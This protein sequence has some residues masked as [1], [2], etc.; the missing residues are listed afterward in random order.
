MSLALT[1]CFQCVQMQIGCARQ[2]TSMQ[3]VSLQEGHA[4]NLAPC[5]KVHITVQLCWCQP[6]QGLL[7]GDGHFCFVSQGAASTACMW[8]CL[9]DVTILAGPL[10]WSKISQC[11]RKKARWQDKTMNWFK[12][13]KN[14][15]TFDDGWWGKNFWTWLHFAKWSPIKFV[16]M[17]EQEIK[18]T[19]ILAGKKV[20]CDD[21]TCVIEMVAL[22]WCIQQAI[23]R[24][25]LRW[26][27]NG[28]EMDYDG[29][30]QNCG[31]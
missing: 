18:S 31:A 8:T 19:S 6:P 12:V 13:A 14:S 29:A 25:F 27:V 24:V 3:N 1:V 4:P 17:V 5:S 26:K 22:I 16:L 11:Q 21:V 7:P 2:C 28:L 9:T 15:L 20:F 23:A 30:H 10:L